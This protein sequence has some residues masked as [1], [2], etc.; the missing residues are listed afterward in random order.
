M[1]LEAHCPCSTSLQGFDFRGAGFWVSGTPIEGLAGPDEI[2]G[3]GGGPLLR[4]CSGARRFPPDLDF[5]L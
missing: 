2:R 1:H 5:R 4:C 3:G